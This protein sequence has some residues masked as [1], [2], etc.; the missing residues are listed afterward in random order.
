MR[1]RIRFN[2]PFTLPGTVAGEPRPAA[3]VEVATLNGQAVV[4][5]ARNERAGAVRAR[6]ADLE[7][8]AQDVRDAMTGAREATV[9]SPA[10]ENRA[11][12]GMGASLA[13]SAPMP[14]PPR[15][16][17]DTE[18]VLSALVLS[19]GAGAVL[20]EGWQRR[21]FTP[22][23]SKAMAG[24]LMGGLASPRFDLTADE[25]E[26]LLFEY[27]LSCEI[28]DEPIPPPT[29]PSARDR[30]G[31]PSLALALAGGANCLVTDNR[32]LLSLGA[33]HS[34]PIVGAEHFLAQLVR[35]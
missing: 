26:D 11:P 2:N 23:V 20:R 18:L 1:A 8:T 25:Q 6:L 13:T 24:E 29:S 35:G 30:F 17:V 12:D 22:L 33:G 14:A 7:L 5:P 10:K 3:C 34:C 15:V 9:T 27:L 28:V 19:G 32:E 31:L 4:T 21:R 16:V